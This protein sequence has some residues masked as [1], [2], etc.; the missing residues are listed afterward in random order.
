MNDKAEPANNWS[1]KEAFRFEV[2]PCE[3]MCCVVWDF[4]RLMFLMLSLRFQTAQAAE[5]ARVK[6]EKRKEKAPVNKDI[7]A[8]SHSGAFYIVFLLSLTIMV[9]FT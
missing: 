8:V 6:I 3:S 4:G 5:L 1:A 7:R 9:R 2:D